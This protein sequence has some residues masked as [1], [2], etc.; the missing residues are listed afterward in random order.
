[1]LHKIIACFALAFALLL[2]G[3]P[4]KVQNPMAGIDSKQPDKALYDRAMES[5]RKGRYTEARSLLDTL[6]NTYPDSEYIARAKLAKGDTWYDEGGSA[7]WKQAEI[8]Y[9]DFQV[10]YPNMPESAEAQLKV[11]TIHYRQMEKADRDFGEAMRAGEEYRN[12]IQQYP[13]TSLVPEAKQRLREVQEVLA[14]RQ[15]RIAHFYYLRDNLAAA[16]ARLQSLI[17]SYPLY[18][19]VDQ[20]LYELGS[21]YEREANAVNRQ[22][23][24]QAATKEKLVSHFQK[25]AIDAYTRIIERYPAMGRAGDA[26]KRLQAL[27]APVPTPTAEAMAESKAEQQSRGSMSL[28]TRVIGNFKKHPNVARASQTGDPPL[29]EEATFNPALLVQD[30]NKQLTGAAAT[31]TQKL[32]LEPVS[33]GSGATPGPNQPPPGSSGS[34]QPPAAGSA[35]P[36]TDSAPP[37]TAPPQVNEVQKDSGANTQAPGSAQGTQ[38][39]Q[40]SSTD[41]KQDSTSKKKNKKGLRKLIPF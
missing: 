35:T 7:A 29:N 34:A 23:I 25:G 11:A 14:E 13:D 22:P 33:G 9:K 28:T 5:M 3:C 12:L 8:E 20:A 40:S 36:S 17:E 6:I 1:M 38:N 15:Y 21:L 41:G 27:N 30:L 26:R 18:S 2:A 24:L 19:G 16:Q 39:A 4:H 32:S 10:F 37:A 31:G